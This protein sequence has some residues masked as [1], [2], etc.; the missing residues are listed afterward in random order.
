MDWEFEEVRLP[1]DTGE[2]RFVISRFVQWHA[3]YSHKAE[4]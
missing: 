3:I 4:P 2:E 1:R